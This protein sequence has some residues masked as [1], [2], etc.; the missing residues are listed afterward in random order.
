MTTSYFSCSICSDWE[1]EADE[2]GD[3]FAKAGERR[4][5]GGA[6]EGRTRSSREEAENSVKVGIMADQTDGIQ[7]KAIVSG[8]I[9]IY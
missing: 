7:K 3:G 2:E 4:G 8:S 5:R 9:A 6:K 1:P